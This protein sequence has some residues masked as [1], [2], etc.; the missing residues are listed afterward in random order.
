MKSVSDEMMIV[1]IVN[2]NRSLLLFSLTGV[3]KG[4][5]VYEARGVTSLLVE[6]GKNNFK[7]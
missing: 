5:T 6:G 7:S 1:K 2:F 4:W 3:P